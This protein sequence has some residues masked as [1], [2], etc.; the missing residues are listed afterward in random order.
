MKVWVTKYWSTQGIYKTETDEKMGRD[1]K[2]VYTKA[3]RGA[4]PIQLKLGRDAFLNEPGARQYA[5]EQ[6]V[7]KIDL[8]RKQITKLERMKI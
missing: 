5:L 8:L 4:L 6:R 7:K 3:E 1:S 2:Y